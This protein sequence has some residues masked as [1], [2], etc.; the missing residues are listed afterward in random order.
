MSHVMNF[1]GIVLLL[2]AATFFFLNLAGDGLTEFVSVFYPTAVLACA[3]FIGAISVGWR[4][5]E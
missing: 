2:M 4:E 3:C 1:F 5:A